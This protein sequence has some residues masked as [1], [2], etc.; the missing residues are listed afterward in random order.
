MKKK[1]LEIALQKVRGFEDPDPSLEQYATPATIAADV[2]FSA[3]SAGDIAGLKVADLG[4]G[5]GMLS[6]G[7]SLAGA[8]S[9]KGFDISGKALEIARRNALD[10]GCGIE[11]EEK[12]ILSVNEPADTVIMNPPFGCQNRNAD[13]PFLRKAMELSDCVYSF[14]MENS[15]EFVAGF[16]RREGREA[17]LCKTYK[18]DIPHTFAFH[19][20]AKQTVD[21]AVV[22]IR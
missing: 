22:V 7:A 21:V 18:Y 20:K 19:K 2:I 13:R 6:I 11:F 3:Y 17:T 14:H 8:G 12:D 9:V 5:T 15:L 10:L 1:E 16:C 4:C